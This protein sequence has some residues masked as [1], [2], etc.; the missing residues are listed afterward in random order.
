MILLS[1]VLAL[2][3]E[4]ALSHLEGWREHALFERYVRWFHRVA[5][6]GLW[7]TPFALLWLLAPTLAVTAAVQ[8]LLTDAVYGLL[9]FVFAT[10]V[11][12]LS[13]GPRD[14]GEEIHALLAA[15]ENG[16]TETAAALKA[17][18]L[19]TP[20][21][22]TK[23]CEGDDRRSV[24]AAICIQA[25][26]RSFA[27]LMWFFVLG[28]VGAVAYRI[29]AGLPRVLLDAGDSPRALEPAT[30]LH[31]IMAWAPARITQMLYALSGSTDDALAE[32]H[33]VLQTPAVS[34]VADT[35]RQLAVVGVGALSVQD[36]GETTTRPARSLESS[37]EAVLGLRG[38]AL[39]VLLALLA[40]PTIGGWLG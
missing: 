11:L 34:W 36:S 40:L 12:L 25:H 10:L 22:L 13:L 39:L 28:P 14:L 8:I 2:V 3:L 30:R 18:L 26:E 29:I 9:E 21:R 27:V 15:Q 19:S 35:W 38:R 23:A 33:R 4:R 6:A 37:L 16:D 1:M 31:A 5:P 24:I 20:G 7:N 32:R 17:D